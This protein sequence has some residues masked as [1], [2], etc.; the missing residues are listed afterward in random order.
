[1]NRLV[2]E[3]MA[4]QKLKLI[5]I[6]CISLLVSSICLETITISTA[7]CM[8]LECTENCTIGIYPSLELQ[9]LKTEVMHDLSGSCVLKSTG[10]S[11]KE[12]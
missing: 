1:M 7:F 5:L 12:S 11:H 6:H 10:Q 3:Q 2:N 9:D 8:Q 4:D